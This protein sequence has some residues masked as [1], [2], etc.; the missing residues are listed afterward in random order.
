[1]AG[2][3]FKFVFFLSFQLTKGGVDKVSAQP[4]IDGSAK[5]QRIEVG[6]Y[7]APEEVGFSGWISTDDWII[8]QSIDDQLWVYNG[9]DE[10]G[11]VTG[12]ATIVEPA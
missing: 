10:D 2:R 5:M 1:M 9:L 7:D 11:G 8:F 6:R 4:P 3:I 12:D